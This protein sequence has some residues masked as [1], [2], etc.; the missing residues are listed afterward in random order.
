MDDGT[1]SRAG[2]GPSPDQLSGGMPDGSPDIV[3]PGML[4]T[5]P[6]DVA[7]VFASCNG[8]DELCQKKYSE[9]TFIGSH[10]SAFVGPTF[11]HNQYVSVTKQ[12]DLGVRFLQAQTHNKAGVIEMCHT[13]CWELDS[14][15]LDTYLREIAAWMNGNPREVVTLLLTNGDGIAVEKFDAVFQSTGLKKHVYRP[16]R[17]GRVS[18]TEWPTLGQLINAHTRLVVFMDYHTDRR[19]VDYIISQFDHYWE[20][21]FGITDK[22]FPTCSVDRPRFGDPQRLMGIMNHMLNF[23]IGDIVFPDQMDAETTNSLDSITKQ[24]NLCES[25]GKP[26]PNVIMLDYI[27]VG[28]ATKAQLVFNGLA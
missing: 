9:V 8:H 19:R 17:G 6:M 21:P 25:Q 4:V 5:G 23:R 10:N 7:T 27:N 18:K 24:V 14:G 12:L 13:Y 2:A 11:A 3:R 28:E 1:R 15:S 20:T 16:A 26:Q 22:N